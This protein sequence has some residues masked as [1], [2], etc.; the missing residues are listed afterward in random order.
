MTKR[1]QE[2]YMF[3]LFT[4]CDLICDVIIAVFE[5]AIP[6]LVKSLYIIKSWLKKTTAKIWKS[7]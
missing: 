3:V 1:A 6:V 4:L 5:A 7:H 2:Y